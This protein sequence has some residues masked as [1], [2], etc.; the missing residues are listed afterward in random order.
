MCQSLL[1]RPKRVRKLLAAQRV[2]CLPRSPVSDKAQTADTSESF[3]TPL[4]IPPSS[5][6]MKRAKSKGTLFYP[7]SYYR[8][9]AAL[10]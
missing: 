1:S 4:A 10:L 5:R 9:I 7:V 6:T 8:P 2:G 3:P